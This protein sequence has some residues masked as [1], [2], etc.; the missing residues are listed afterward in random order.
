MPDEVS[1]DKDVTCIRCLDMYS[2]LI[3]VGPRILSRSLWGFFD[4]I[5]PNWQSGVPKREKT[6]RVEIN[7]MKLFA[8]GVKGRI[9]S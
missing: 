7:D 8:L 6:V 3:C 1:H 4:P 2:S 9:P 5:P